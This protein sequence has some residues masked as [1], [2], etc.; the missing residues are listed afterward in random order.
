VLG[1]LVLALAAATASAHA[2]QARCGLATARAAIASTHLRMKLLGDSTTRV[3]PKSA[4][5]VICFDFTR[6]GRLD[7]A[8]TIAS[9]GTAGDIGFAVFR[10]TAAG[11]RVALA[12]DGYKLGLFRLR[13]DL[14]G[15]Q[16]VYRKNDPNCCPTGGFD[17]VRY[18]WNGARFVVARSWHTRS[19]R[20]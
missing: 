3:D 6:D 15:S 16:P 20:P 8:V 12:R 17:H 18:H 14:V 5:Q 11:W 13:G 19:F 2:A 7:V 1:V 9:G 10:A 4:D